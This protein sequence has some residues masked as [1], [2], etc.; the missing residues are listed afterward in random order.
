[1]ESDSIEDKELSDLDIYDAYVQFKAGEDHDAAIDNVSADKSDITENTKEKPIAEYQWSEII[2]LDTNLPPVEPCNYK[3]LPDELAAWVKDI[4]ERTQC[5]PDFV[6]VTVMVSLASLIGRKVAIYPKKCDDWLVVPNLWGALIGR[7]SAMKSPAMSEGMRPLKRL[8]AEARKQHEDKIKEYMIEKMFTDQ[9]QKNLELDIKKALKSNK[10]NEI[11]DARANALK[12]V[13]DE[14][15]PFERRY[16]VN[17]ATVEKLGELLNENTNGLLLERDELT[18]WLKNLDREDRANDRTFFL[19]CFNGTGDYTYDRIGRGT[20]YI[21]CTTMSIIGGL[22]PSKLRPYVWNAINH[23]NGDDGLI[24]RFQLAVYPDDVGKWR[25]V[26]RYPNSKDKNKAFE[27][28]KRLDDIKSQPVDDEGRVKGVRFDEGGQKVFNK[29]REDLESKTREQG[30]HPAIESHLTKYRSLMPSIA[31]IINEVEEGHCKPVTEQ[32]A[33]K[34]A[35]WCQ[36]LESHMMRIYGG[37]VDPAAQSADLIL[38]RRDKLPDGF[39]QRDVQRKGW[40]GLSEVGHVKAALT[41]LVECGYLRS[42]QNQQ[43]TSGGRPSS[44]YFWNPKIEKNA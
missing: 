29:W 9:Q 14:K 3:L 27:V 40:A 25:N 13:N 23:G 26:D 11:E 2:P 39:T 44:P 28:F 32:S 12:A 7:P 31:L 33:K 8:V 41:E 36:Y 5:P 20:V 37:A 22:Q 34:A 43:S 30:I 1:M 35:A 24:Q 6:A 19:E 16:I 21:E 15:E 38:G 18:G 17:D 10:R 42:E 4:V